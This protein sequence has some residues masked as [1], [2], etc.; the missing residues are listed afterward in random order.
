MNFVIPKKEMKSENVEIV[1][2]VTI[3]DT[4]LFNNLP[5]ILNVSVKQFVTINNTDTL[6]KIVAL[7]QT[8]TKLKENY[9]NDIHTT[10]ISVMDAIKSSFESQ[11]NLNYYVKG[12]YNSRFNTPCLN[13]WIECNEAKYAAISIIINQLQVNGWKPL[14]TIDNYNFDDDMYHGGNNLIINCTFSF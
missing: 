7:Q 3:N 5:E 11:T 10:Y 9:V 1:K 14:I 6:N 8:N 2:D 13:Y 12:Q 4:H